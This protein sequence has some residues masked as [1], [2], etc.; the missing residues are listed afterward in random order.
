MNS[1]VARPLKRCQCSI[2]GSLKDKGRK[3]LTEASEDIPEDSAYKVHQAHPAQ[4]IQDVN[5][6]V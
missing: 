6:A 5:N 4:P 2:C 3:M 1:K